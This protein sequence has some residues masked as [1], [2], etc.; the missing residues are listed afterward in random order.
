MG[1][2]IKINGFYQMKFYQIVFVILKFKK[3][4]YWARMILLEFVRLKDKIETVV[5]RM[6]GQ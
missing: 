1:I 5:I 3:T 4:I 2:A 6:G